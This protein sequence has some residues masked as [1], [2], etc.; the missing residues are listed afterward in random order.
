MVIGFEAYARKVMQNDKYLFHHFIYQFYCTMDLLKSIDVFRE[1]CAR[2]SFTQAADRLNLVPSAVSRQ[3]SELERHLGVRLL[4]RTT[5]S[6]R[7]TDEGRRYLEKMD[8][9]NQSVG[10]LWELSPDQGR[11]DGHIRLT[12]P[13][14]FGPQFLTDA[15]DAFMGAYPEVSVSTTLVNREVDLI[16]EGY[17]IALRVGDLKNSNLVARVIGGFSLLV[18]ASPAYVDSHPA[19]KHPK[20]L[21]KHNCLLNTLTRSPRR[22]RFQQ[23]KRKFTVKVDGTYE[24]NDD[25]VLRRFATSGFG[26][27][28]LPSYFVRDGIARGELLPLLGAFM[29][30][31]LPI[32]VVYPSRQLLGP[33]KRLLID[34]LVDRMEPNPFARTSD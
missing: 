19:I 16:E 10:A 21:A 3:V 13:P 33:A 15:L 2:M 25:I 32:C 34:H 24:A 17:D 8:A 27:A 23:G 7:L 4:Q 20:D 1:V 28:F 14:L 5:R 22:W 31:P 12:A 29:P 9:I 11:I 26:V 18:V 30:E 6:I